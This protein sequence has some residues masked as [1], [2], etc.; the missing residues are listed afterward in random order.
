M[1]R[2][3]KFLVIDEYLSEDAKQ[4]IAEA[5]TPYTGTHVNHTTSISHIKKVYGKSQVQTKFL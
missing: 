2:F 4:K 3:N 1:S 5:V